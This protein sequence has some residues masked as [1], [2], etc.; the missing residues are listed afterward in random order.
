ML[1]AKRAHI[2]MYAESSGLAAENPDHEARTICQ[3]AALNPAPDQRPRPA[4]PPE[5]I[6]VVPADF[7]IPAELRWRRRWVDVMQMSRSAGGNVRRVDLSRGPGILHA[8]VE[9]YPLAGI[10]LAVEALIRR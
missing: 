9:T 7:P 4:V 2:E 1:P 6:G 3:G 10:T 5:A 8:R